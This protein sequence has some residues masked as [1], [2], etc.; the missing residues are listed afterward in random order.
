MN[1]QNTI[2]E[3]ERLHLTGMKRVYDTV[4]SLP[5]Q[6]QPDIHHFMAQLTEAELQQR[7]H[8]RTEMYLK[9]SKLR[10]DAILEQVHCT[11]DRNLTKES[12]AAI[13]DCGFIKRA[14]NILITG[15]AGCGKSF[16][17]CAIGRQ[18]CAFGYK[19]MYFSMSK[20]L[21]KITLCKL[22]GTL[23]KFLNQI[24]KV[25]LLILDDFGMHPLD[26]NV[27]L[28]LLQILEDRY[29]KHSAIITS[30]LP[31]ANWYE[32]INES[33]VADAIMDR[34]AGIAHRFE[35]KGQSLRKKYIN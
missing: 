7:L 22:E 11:T 29:G 23:L 4:L 27:R 28:A 1:S 26:A 10:Y 9:L 21:E 31:V 30:Q 12:I 19:T 8:N 5:Q 25:H 33:T 17:A 24:E 2:Y 18:A 13:A 6:E 32:Y 20:F 3:L 15:A 14:E 35:L 16:L 34:L